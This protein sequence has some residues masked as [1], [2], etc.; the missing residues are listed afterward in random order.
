MSITPPSKK[1]FPSAKKV[2][3]RK[4]WIIISA[5]LLV[6]VGIYGVLKVQDNNRKHDAKAQIEQIFN[7]VPIKGEVIFKNVYD[8]GCSTGASGWVGVYTTCDYSGDLVVRSSG[9]IA[10]DLSEINSQLQILGWSFAVLPE[11]LSK[12]RLENVGNF[13][14]VHYG[15]G[16][17][18][19]IDLSA[20][21]G[22]SKEISDINKIHNFNTHIQI[23]ENAYIYSVHIRAQYRTSDLPFGWFGH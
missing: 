15:K 12:E 3:V 19:A 4:S 21:R 18:T 23:E 5:I 10:K 1:K 9:D 22:G 7:I 11:D 2:N 17:R 14:T 16:A 13:S 8:Q 6:F 20:F